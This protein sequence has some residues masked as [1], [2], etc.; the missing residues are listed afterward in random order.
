MRTAT[1]AS[2]P[3]GTRKNPHTAQDNGRR[4]HLRGPNLGPTERLGLRAALR[5]P[6]SKFVAG[7]ASDATPGVRLPS[8][9][10]PVGTHRPVVDNFW[11]VL[12]LLSNAGSSEFAPADDTPRCR[13]E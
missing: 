4:S 12:R 13:A 3:V 11:A 1:G 7:Q 10:G 9:D 8:V 2:V 6:R 5:Q